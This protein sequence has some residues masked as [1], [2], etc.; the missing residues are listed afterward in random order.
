MEALIIAAGQGSR[1]RKRFS[2]K[3]LLKIFGL[4]LLERIILSAKNAGIHDF[5]IVL[6]YK[7]ALIKK[8]IGNGEKYGVHIEYILNP[9]WKNGNGVSVL[10]AKDHMKERFL[11]LMSDHI[12]D[13]SILKKLLQTDLEDGHCTLYIDK[14][15]IGDHIL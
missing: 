14:N 7:A 12:F 2:T 15:L 3:P 8:E 6:G 5:K 13:A 11:L 4:R 9:D 10:K 1:L